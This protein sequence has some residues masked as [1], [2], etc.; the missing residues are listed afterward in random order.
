MSRGWLE[1]L[2]ESTE[3]ANG[4]SGKAKRP[5]ILHQEFVLNRIKIIRDIGDNKSLIRAVQKSSR[6]IFLVPKP[7]IKE[8][9]VTR[10]VQLKPGTNWSSRM[11]SREVCPFNLVTKRPEQDFV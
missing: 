1:N 10:I 9:R 7:D 5:K 8:A 6:S 4:L 3:E 11:T 2:E